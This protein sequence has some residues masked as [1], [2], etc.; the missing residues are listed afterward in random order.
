M[1]S[2]NAKTAV[3]A[4]FIFDPAHAATLRLHR[5]FPLLACSQVRDDNDTGEKVPQLSLQGAPVRACYHRPA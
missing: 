4:S 3:C 1:S 2:G 5:K